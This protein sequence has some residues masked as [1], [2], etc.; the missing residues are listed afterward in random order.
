MTLAGLSGELS[1]LAV[2][3]HETVKHMDIGDRDAFVHNEDLV[4]LFQGLYFASL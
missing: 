3:V 1:D 4:H 2:C